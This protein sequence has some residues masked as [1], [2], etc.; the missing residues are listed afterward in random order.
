VIEIG[1]GEVSIAVVS[2]ITGKLFV[3]SEAVLA[4][5][6]KIYQEYLDVCLTAHDA[7][8]Q[9]AE[10]P[11]KDDQVIVDLEKIRPKGEFF[12]YASQEI[13][14]LAGLHVETLS[15]AYGEI[16][17]TTEA[18]HPAFTTSIQ[19]Y[20]RMLIAMRRDVMGW[21]FQGIFERVFGD[22][23]ARKLLANEHPQTLD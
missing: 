6:K 19:A 4:Q 11:E 8:K 22:R 10:N 13:I 16:D 7:Y 2:F 14:I 20:N 12:L 5:K 3:Q 18:L 17:E 9:S 1:L 23:K 21:S 15:K